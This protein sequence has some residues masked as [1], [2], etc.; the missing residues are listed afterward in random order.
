MDYLSPLMSNEELIA[1]DKTMHDLFRDDPERFMPGYGVPARYHAVTL[2]NFSGGEQYVARLRQ[3]V[4]APEESALLYGPCGSGKTHLAVGTLKA[5][6]ARIPEWSRETLFVTVPDL[7]EG[8]RASFRGV[9][10]EDPG[11]LT[12]YSTCAFLVLD[13]LGA[14]RATDFTLDRLY[15]ILSRRINAFLPTVVTTN[16]D[17]AE[18]KA[19]LDPR[20]ASRLSGF[21]CIH[22]RMPDHRKARS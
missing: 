11:S 5:M 17:P 10:A 8:I 22:V 20:I 15:L 1:H 4:E 13:D 12:R 2:E 9:D 7:L 14:E 16:L 21:L 6:R 19:K 18:I 3:F